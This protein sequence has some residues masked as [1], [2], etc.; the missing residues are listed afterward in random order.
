MNS[1]RVSVSCL[2]RSRVSAVGAGH[3]HPVGGDGPDPLERGCTVAGSAGSVVGSVGSTTVSPFALTRGSPTSAMPGSAA[4]R[5]ASSG[6]SSAPSPVPCRSATTSSGAL[7]PGPK[8]SASRSYALRSVVARRVVAG[9]RE[10]GVQRQRRGGQRQEQERRRRPGTARAGR[11][12]GGPA[13]TRRWPRPA[14]RRGAGRR[15]VPRRCGRRA[16]TGCAGSRVSAVATANSTTIDVASP[17]EARK[18]TPVSTSAAIASDH[19][20]AGEEDGRAGRAHGGGQRLRVGLPG[21]AVLAVAGD[22]E[23]GVV[24][25]DAQPDHRAD[26]RRGGGDVQAAGQQHDAAEPDGDGDQREHDRHE[27]GHDGA[28]GDEE[29]DERGEHADRLGARGLLLGVEE[30]GVAAE[31][32]RQPVGAGRLEG[33]R[34][35]SPPL[36][37]PNSVDGTSRVISA[38]PIRPSA[39]TRSGRERVA[40]GGDVLDVGDLRQRRLDG[41]PEARP[42]ARRRGR[43]TRRLRCRRPPAGKRSSSSSIASALSLPGALK[44]SANAPPRAPESATTSAA[45]TAHA[46]IVLHGLRALASPMR[47]M[48]RFM[49]RLAAG[50]GLVGT[51]VVAVSES[52]LVMSICLS[53]R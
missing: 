24:D 29:D 4:M 32:G 43:R 52:V 40:H 8:P 7:K 45:R 34:P 15:S 51:A 16:A 50:G 5:S 17:M 11:R 38:N 28:E 31:L 3:V 37:R 39:E 26:R 47:R 36:S 27:G 33:V 53:E 35:A 13:A 49:L 41:R 6:M 25:A 14:W 19:G 12:S 1:G 2:S 20:A 9:V 10:A 23:Q 18:P 22:D 21:G 30:R 44:S 42:A 48:K 46:P